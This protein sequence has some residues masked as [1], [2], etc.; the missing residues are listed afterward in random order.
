M[1]MAFLGA[2]LGLA[3]KPQAQ[4]VQ[5]DPMFKVPS[6]LLLGANQPA[7]PPTHPPP[8]TTTIRA[9]QVKGSA[10]L[11]VDA[12]ANSALDAQ[13]AR[14]HQE[15][16]QVKLALKGA[17]SKHFL[18][19]QSDIDETVCTDGFSL[20][21][22]GTNCV[23]DAVWEAANGNK[24]CDCKGGVCKNCCKEEI[25]ANGDWACSWE[26]QDFEADPTHGYIADDA[27]NEGY[28]R[29]YTGTNCVGD[30]AW[31]AAN[32]DKACD[33]VAGVCAKCCKEE[34]GDDNTWS[35]FW[36]DPD[37]EWANEHSNENEHAF[38][39][40]DSCET[41]F[42]R[43][44]GGS[45]CVGDAAWIKENGNSACECT[46]GTCKMCCKEDVTD[47]GA[48]AC[49]WAEPVTSYEFVYDADCPDGFSR[50]YAGTNCAGQ[51]SWQCDC[52]D[53]ECSK[54][55]KETVA[56]DDATAWSCFW[57]YQYPASPP[58][59]PPHTPPPGSPPPPPRAFG[60]DVCAELNGT[61]YGFCEETGLHVCC[62][63]CDNAPTTTPT[64]TPAVSI[65]I[66]APVPTPGAGTQQGSQQAGTQQGTQQGQSGVAAAQQGIAGALPNIT[67]PNLTQSDPMAA[68]AVQQEANA[69]ASAAAAI[70]GVIE[71]TS[72]TKG[73]SLWHRKDGSVING[74]AQLN[75]AAEAR[76]RRGA[77]NPNQVL[78]APYPYPYPYP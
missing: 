22:S 6:P 25:A 14:L 7:H 66:T 8:T 9:P 19:A 70:E 62:G 76:K 50:T 27:C 36:Q 54:C 68:S 71:G 39:A 35:C 72:P 42:S 20:E 13:E 69:Q 2:G 53:G 56:A 63:V 46:D 4:A 41:G 51:E 74:A 12:L 47:D 34:A 64:P 44:Y 37:T 45:N 15:G 52:T 49:S 23:G 26:E 73:K 48:W 61:N 16:V 1:M 60:E 24:A 30:A 78:F 57:E 59:L 43:T 77:K 67:M 40:D 17:G 3:G 18:K 28:S 75:L 11:P 21:Y 38:V 31:E 5:G 55:C 58:P 29:N 10:L 32:G 65:A 33:C